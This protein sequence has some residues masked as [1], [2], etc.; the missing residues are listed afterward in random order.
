MTENNEPLKENGTS[1][2][3]Y[4]AA[5]IT[6]LREVRKAF[7]IKQLLKEIQKRG[8]A[9]R[10]VEK[11]NF[12]NHSI[13]ARALNEAKILTIFPGIE[14]SKSSILSTFRVSRE[15]SYFT[16]LYNIY[17]LS[18]REL[19]TAILEW[20]C[21]ISKNPR[22]LLTQ[23]QHEVL[24]GM[25]LGDGNL[26]HR[27]KN[28]LF[29]TEHS[30]KQKEYLFWTYRLFKE[31][32]LSEPKGVTREHHKNDEY[33]FTTFAH[34]VF[35]SYFELFYKNGCKRVTKEILEL[36][37]PES[38][39]IWICDD[40]SY[41]NSGKHIILCTNSFL[42]NEHKIMQK[43]FKEKW[44]LNCSIRFRNQKYY[45]LSF[46]QAD[47]KKLANIIRNY[48]PLENLKYKIGEKDD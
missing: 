16:K 8:D 28:T 35:N 4:G 2:E 45:Y 37:T 17:G 25:L 14:K 1:P 42:L 38:L 26:R 46:Y 44:N 23:K 6:T 47:T 39:S 10:L 15:F 41:S 30:E 21:L 33:S 20:K 48:I 27:G 32:T 22:L 40:G 3:A 43:Y 18:V 31:F 12:K 19:R 5:Q 9:K 7:D 11:Y 36:L 29:R 13:L 24:M 34:P